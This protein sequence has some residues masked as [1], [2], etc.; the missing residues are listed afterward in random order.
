MAE[1]NATGRIEVNAS[2]QQVYELVSD[3]AVLAELA[4]EYSGHKW[5]DGASKAVVGAKFR[6]SNRRGV[7][8]W[9][10]TSEITDAWAG[11]RFAFE[12]TSVAGL[13]VSRWQ[14][15]IT[16]TETGCVVTESTW[17]RRPAWFRL[18]TS[19]VTGV[20]ERD[21]QNQRNIEAT[22]RRLKARAENGSH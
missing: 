12:V 16:A 4:E 11:R 9:S 15:D 20:F 21:E 8:R 7:R 6:G 19:A 2:P 17:E 22:L 5:L 3:P 13:P 10:T 14:Y 18:P 1:P